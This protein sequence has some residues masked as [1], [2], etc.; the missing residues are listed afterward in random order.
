MSFTI[1]QINLKNKGASASAIL[2][3]EKE[4]RTA[5]G[6]LNA[7]KEDLLLKADA[8]GQKLT[9][10]G[11]LDAAKQNQ[12]KNIKMKLEEMDFR[13]AT[14]KAKIDILQKLTNTVSGFILDEKKMYSDKNIAAIVT[15]ALTAGTGLPYRK[16]TIEMM[17]G[18]GMTP[19]MIRRA[20]GGD[21]LLEGTGY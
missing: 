3:A 20:Q 1:F 11:Q 4:R 15:S 10:S 2:A 16:R 18:L 13:T 8:E 5:K 12:V 9:A 14:K 6:K 21:K 19:D 17:I 7:R